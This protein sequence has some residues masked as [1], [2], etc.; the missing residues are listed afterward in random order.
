MKARLLIG[1]VLGLLIAV[2]AVSSAQQPGEIFGKVTDTSGAVMPGV[3]VTLTSPVLLEPQT[4]MTSE[5]GTY[6][7]PQLAIGLYSVR[8]ELPGFRTVVREGI[9][10]EIGFNAQINA[11]LEVSAV[12]E[13][14]TVTGESPI[15]DT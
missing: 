11:T 15:V 10:I 2:P 3:N 13:T 9:R 1:L 14:V 8:F 7:F 6:R 5:T 12:Q 4:A